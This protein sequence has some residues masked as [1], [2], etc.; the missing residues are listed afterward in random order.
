VHWPRNI[1]DPLLPPVLEPVVQLI[2]DLFSCYPRRANP[3]RLSESLQPSRDIDSIAEEV[4]TLNHG[5]ADMDPDAEPHLLAGRSIHVLLGYGVLHRDGT[6]HSIHGTGEI[7]D[8]A[9]ARRVED[10]T[11]MGG[12]QTI[13]DNFVSRKRAKGADLI[14]T[15]EGA[16]ARDIGGENRGELPFDG[17]RFQGSSSSLPR[18]IARY[19]KRSERS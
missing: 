18:I 2:A 12:D 6:L 8:E 10:P 14:P 4:V 11:A 5:V 9:I 1:F 7:G 13:D 16:V 19:L 3:A 15:H 17:W